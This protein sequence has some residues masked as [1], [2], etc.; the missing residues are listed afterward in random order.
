M[1]QFWRAIQQ[2]RRDRGLSVPQPV[3]AANPPAAPSPPAPSTPAPPTP[4]A[5]PPARPQI[6]AL[7]PKREA[8]ARSV[9]DRATESMARVDDHLVSLL[10]PASFAA[11]QYRTLRHTIEEAHRE[12]GL[13]VVG[14]SSPSVGDGKTTTAINL[15]GALSQAS[16]ARVLLV[17]LDLRRPSIGRLLGLP[18][19]QPGLVDAVI[20]SRVELVD[21]ATTVRPFNFAVVLA[22]QSAKTPYELLKAPRLGTLMAKARESYDYVILDAPPLQPMPDCQLIGGFVDKFVVVLAC[23]KTPR[24]LLG[25]A[26]NVLAPDKVLGLVFNRNDEL[27]SDYRPEDYGTATRG[28]RWSRAAKRMAQ[29]EGHSRNGG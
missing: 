24:R 20:D 13:S 15:A 5:H 11:E 19:N 21:V 1:S 27:L 23:D 17:D 18:A 9:V 16:D 22:G 26:L 14:V 4:V 10:A 12:T 7:E 29:T 2:S 25:E 28:P 8:P 6:T 3:P